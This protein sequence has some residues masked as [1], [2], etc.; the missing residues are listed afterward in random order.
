MMIYDFEFVDSSWDVQVP[1][2]L[3]PVE[4]DCEIK[5][6]IDFRVALIVK[7][8]LLEKLRVNTSNT[9]SNDKIAPF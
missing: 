7:L 3:Q 5:P 6:M 8:N 2:H 4:S 1:P 9:T